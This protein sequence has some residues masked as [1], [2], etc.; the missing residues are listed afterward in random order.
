M[1]EIAIDENNNNV[2][3]NEERPVCHINYDDEKNWDDYRQIARD[4]LT[5]YANVPIV[6]IRASAGAFS[7]NWLAVAL[8]VASCFIKNQLECVVFKVSNREKAMAS[9]RPFIALTVGLKYIIHLYQDELGS[10]YREIAGLSYLGIDIQ[11]NFYENKLYMTYRQS[12]DTVSDHLLVAHTKEEALT[13]TGILKTISLTQKPAHIKAE[14]FKTND[15]TLPD[16]DAAIRNVVSYV[17]PW[18]S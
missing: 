6:L 9:Y 14:I 2:F 11:E 8:F 10:M 12:Y 17:R 4:I 5:T 1:I 3:L 16:I 13:V 15:T 18:M 7:N